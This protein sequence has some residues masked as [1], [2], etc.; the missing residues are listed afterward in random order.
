ME[1]STDLFDEARI[2]RM[3]DHFQ[4][5]V[6]AAAADPDL[7]VGRL[8]ILTPA[9]R[10]FLLVDCNQTNWPLVHEHLLHEL[11]ERHARR[12]PSAVAAS[13]N[14]RTITYRELEERSSLLARH[15][16]GLGVKPGVL[17][18]I[19]VERS[20]EMIVALMAVLKAGGAYV[21][22]DPTFPSDRISYMLENSA[23]A[24]VIKDRQLKDKITTASAK[25]V[26]LDEDWQAHTPRDLPPQDAA[27][28]DDPAY[29]IYTSGSTGRP[30]GVVIPHRAVVNFMISMARKPGFTST[31][32]IVAVTTLSFDIAAL[33]IFLPLTQGAR[34]EIASRETATDPSRLS[35]LLSKCKA[36]V[37]QATPATW[38]MLIDSGWQGNRDLKILC[39]G[40][41][42]SS[43]LATQ[44]I[45]RSGELWNMYGPT[46]TTIWSTIERV[47]TADAGILIGRPIQNTQAYILDRNLEPLPAGIPGELF[48]GGL[49]LALG[50]LH[51]P[52]LT[53]ERFLPNPFSSEPGSRMYR[54]GDVARYRED[55]RIEC[56]GR[57][58]HQV[59]IRG[60]RIEVA[61]IESVLK[62]HPS[63][64]ECVVIAT[65]VGA[66]DK[67]LVAVITAVDP[68]APPR[69]KELERFLKQQ[70][71]EY[72][73][74]STIAIFERLPLTPNGKVDRKVLA[75]NDY[76]TIEQQEPQQVKDPTTAQELQLLQIW[77]RVLSRQNIGIRDNFFDLGGHSLLAVRLVAEINKLL[78]INFTL[79][80]F[81]LNPTIEDLAQVLRKKHLLTP[82]PKLMRLYP[83]ESGGSLFFLDDSIGMN[84]LA[85][86]LDVGTKSFIASV[87]FSPQV[88]EMALNKKLASSLR[89][90]ELAAPFAKLIESQQPTG[91]CTLVAHCFTALM[92]FEAA[93]QLALK[94]I[95]V[96]TIVLLDAWRM[97]PRW[98]QRLQL[99][100]GD[101]ARGAISWRLN[102]L[103]RG[104]TNFVHRKMGTP[105]SLQ[106]LEPPTELSD[107]DLP[108]EIR[109]TIYRNA[110][111]NYSWRPIE[112]KGI[113][114]RAQKDYWAPLHPSNKALGWEGLFKG[115]VEVV[116]T[117]ADHY[118]VLA[119][120][121]ITKVAEVVKKRLAELEG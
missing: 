111:K 12:S 99:M 110:R 81:F 69:T 93:Q 118:T 17:V 88:I 4:T 23:A 8:P 67:R 44:L 96:E 46:E 119:F 1:F 72:M 38:R 77:Q 35:S 55:G 53:A 31:D 91:S 86:L 112:G 13:F 15:L 42:L 36:T 106:P 54:T 66:G 60:F 19:C 5:I 34:V 62:Q 116:D 82:G 89:L 50:Y 114:I 22:V 109:K 6:S 85:Q 120:P 48:I 37:M 92:A 83:G 98:W 65:D 80:M 103:R 25:I 20:I 29:V 117:P 121:H 108:L 57:L 11:I 101:R 58:D 87:P 73:I 70:L 30:K 100:S 2:T 39:G 26:N 51:Q 7:P 113:L 21:P 64:G 45:A 3:L 74:P 68:E 33:E 78:D 40:E 52:E 27:T 24:V 14:G 16:R 94:N 97:P 107:D 49:G 63:V 76:T 115:G 79:P 61:E 18:A 75:L 71:P 84:R 90:E 102:H 56:F 95:K 59:K 41:S 43:D 105:D 10:Q 104:I 9:E 47:E 32:I 28:L